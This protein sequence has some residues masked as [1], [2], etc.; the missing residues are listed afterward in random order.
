M[1]AIGKRKAKSIA[2]ALGNLRQ[3]EKPTETDIDET[4][5]GICKLIGP[6]FLDEVNRVSQNW[7]ENI[8]PITV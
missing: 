5:R 6:D 4:I 3:V 7:D 1:E 8:P 2:E